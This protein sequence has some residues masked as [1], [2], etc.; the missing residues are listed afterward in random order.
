MT[1][2]SQASRRA[3]AAL[4]GPDQSRVAAGA[5]S[6]R[7]Q[8]LQ[9]HRDGD[10]GP[11]AVPGRGA[12]AIADRRSSSARASALRWP[13]GPQVRR[14]VGGRRRGPASGCSWESNS[15]VSSAPRRA[16]HVGAAVCRAGGPRAPG[17]P[18]WCS[19]FVGQGLP[20]LGVQR[21]GA[22]AGPTGP[23]PWGRAGWPASTRNASACS[24][25]VPSSEPGGRGQRLAG[26]R[27]VLG[28]RSSPAANAARSRCAAARCGRRRPRGAPGH[29]TGRRAVPG[30]GHQ[31]PRGAGVQVQPGPQPAGRRVR[32][33]AV[34]APRAS[35][36]RTRPCSTASAAHESRR[37]SRLGCL[38]QLRA[39]Q[40][41][42]LAVGARH[43]QLTPAA[44]ARAQSTCSAAVTGWVTGGS[45]DL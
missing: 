11:G 10:A 34:A 24:A 42:Q 15:A 8:G 26:D 32:P 5:P 44:R 12:P 38:E 29:R 19:S 30:S 41:P 16:A 4:I 40:R 2:A 35:I 22:G 43:R 17:A 14:A 25:T 20:G 18:A 33:V 7:S 36:S 37:C 27:S 45:G 23:A 39:G 9:G 3:V 6:R 21:R 31:P 13:D 28:R 1:W